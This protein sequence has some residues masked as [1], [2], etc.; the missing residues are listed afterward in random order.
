MSRSALVGASK[1]SCTSVAD[2]LQIIYVSGPAV[3][4][5]RYLVPHLETRNR[6]LVLRAFC[7]GCFL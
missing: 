3:I 2:W 1:P 6:S 5:L 4:F 7:L